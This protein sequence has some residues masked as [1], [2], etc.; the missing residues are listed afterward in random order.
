MELPELLAPLESLLLLRLLRLSL[1]ASSSVVLMLLPLLAL[2]LLVSATLASLHR[3]GLGVLGVDLAKA[4]QPLGSQLCQLTILLRVAT[5]QHQVT[6][7]ARLAFGL[8]IE[9]EPAHALQ[10]LGLEALLGLNSEPLCSRLLL[11]FFDFGDADAEPVR[12]LELLLLLVNHVFVG[13]RNR[14]VSMAEALLAKFFPLLLA[15]FLKLALSDSRFK[16]RLHEVDDL[17]GLL[18]RSRLGR[19]RWGFRGR[20][21]CQDLR[22]RCFLDS[23]RR[24]SN[25][26]LGDRLGRDWLRLFLLGCGQ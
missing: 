8:D 18:D 2:H 25:C 5:A 10:L 9:P 16:R 4:R 26:L 6:V 15:Q 12:A 13:L 14:S 11:L 3:N 17:L 1:A 23:S 20:G 22:R 24:G 7:V 21:L 19:R